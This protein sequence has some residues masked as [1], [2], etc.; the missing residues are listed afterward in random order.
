MAA[1][2]GLA[3]IYPARVVDRVAVVEV[4][5]NSFGT[6][7]GVARMPDALVG[8]GMYEVLGRLAEV[9]R[10]RVTFETPRSVRGPAGLLAEP[11]LVS[12]VENLSEIVGHTVAG[13]HWPL[14]I[15][16][17]CAVLLGALLGVRRAGYRPG[18]LFVDGHE[19]AWPPH[20]SP[21]GEAAD[22]EMGLALGLYPP[23]AALRAHVPLVAP[24]MVVP[25]GPRDSAEL[26]NASV[27]S[28][29]NRLRM[30]TGAELVNGDTTE[31]AT[32]A[33]DHLRAETEKWWLHVDLDVMSTEALPAV[34]YPQP[35][36]LSCPG[37]VGSP[38]RR[39]GRVAA[40]ARRSS[41]TTQVVTTERTPRS[42]CD[43]SLT[44]CPPAYRA[45]KPDRPYRTNDPEPNTPSGGCSGT[46]RLSLA[47]RTSRPGLRR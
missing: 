6:A 34:D 18:L 7:D 20:R 17:D 46:A 29:A 35:G 8:A 39:S 25:L 28:L 3:D 43:T 11:A 26:S 4:P 32:S 42:S 19:D 10:A 47:W 14:V 21:T 5:F 9:N 16:G 36:G 2:P 22:C 24:E 38:G 45:R 37:S 23:P 44:S 31:I 27:E 15:G 41:S 33:A 13:G 12:M 40:S 30:V 1:R